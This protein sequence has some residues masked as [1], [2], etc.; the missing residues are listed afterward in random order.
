[1]LTTAVKEVKK[2][3]SDWYTA[4]IIAG[5]FILYLE[6]APAHARQ[7]MINDPKISH[8]FA[9]PQIVNDTK[10]YVLVFVIPVLLISLISYLKAPAKF[11]KLAHVT[12]LGLF[13]SFVITGFITDLLKIWISRPR[14]DFVT[15]CIPKSSTPLNTYVS[16][17]V[18]TQEN[19]FLLNDGLKSCPSGHSSLSMSGALFFCLWVQGQFKLFHSKSL[20]KQLLGW[21][22]IL[23]ALFIAIS[24]H[25]DYRHHVEDI[26]FGLCIGG[27]TSGI[28]YFKYFP[29]LWSQ[30]CDLVLD[31]VN[32]L[33]R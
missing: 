3:A 12:I 7:F 24:R 10:L 26:V 5:V 21:S 32:V 18:C 23:V 11:I 2:Y 13:I 14:P 27:I 9:N 31:E 8:S 17:E 22:Y 30:E 20:W 15:R 33:P 16:L 25:I 6:L 1:M 4:A 29:S 19:R 28:I